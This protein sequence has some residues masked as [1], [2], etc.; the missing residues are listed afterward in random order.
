MKTARAI[1]PNSG[2]E[3]WYR[4][5]LQCVTERMGQ[6]MLL[7][8]RVAW[9][10]ADPT[11]GMAHDAVNGSLFI[12]RAMSKYG[13]QWTLR[14]NRLS[15]DLSR[16]FANK[17]YRATEVQMRA[18]FRDAGMT[19]KFKPTEASKAAYQATVAENVALIKSIPQKFL[20][21]V[22]TQVW[23]AVMRGSTLGELT[24]IIR[25]KYGVA[26]KRAALIATD[27]NAKAK[28]IIENTRRRELGIVEGVWLHSS[29]GVEPR[30]THA[31]MNGKRYALSDGMYDSAEQEQIWP[32]QLINCRCSSKPVL[33]G[34]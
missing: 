15:V 22:E 4:D 5:Q 28:A 3:R 30:P 6:S 8:I 14:L 23:G 13:K 26:L 7:H 1:W 27:Q 9:R 24:D 18:S 29:A 33:P 10:E 17:A 21:D 19:V 2:V 12:K 20:T 16:R 11:H 31:A 32:G 25:D 34:F